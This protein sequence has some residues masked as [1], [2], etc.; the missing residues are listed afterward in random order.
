M[1]TILEIVLTSYFVISQLTIILF[2]FIERSARNTRW[3]I[4]LMTLANP[5]VV[6]VLSTISLIEDHK[7]KK[8][9]AK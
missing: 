2:V 6:I 8:R 3:F 4:T 1:M 9:K 7:D 5:I